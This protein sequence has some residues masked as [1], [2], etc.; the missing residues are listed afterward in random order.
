MGLTECD[1]D[2]GHTSP[3]YINHLPHDFAEKQEH[4]PY[5]PPPRPNLYLYSPSSNSLIPCEEI[6]VPNP[7]MSADGPVYSGPTNIYLAYPVQ[8]PDGIGYITQPFTPP[9]SYISQGSAS[10]SPSMSYD[11]TN[12]YSSTPHTFNSGRDSGWSTQPTSPPPPGNLQKPQ[13]TK[14][15][16]Y[17]H[18][19][20]TEGYYDPVPNNSAT[21]KSS[22]LNTPMS[23]TINTVTTQEPRQTVPYIPGLS[24]ESANTHKK[25][26]K[27]RKKKAKQECSATDFDILKSSSP[28]EI[29]NLK[30]NV[31]QHERTGE[32]V[33]EAPDEPIHE[34]HLTDDLADSLVNPPTDQEGS[35]EEEKNLRFLSHSQRPPQNEE[36]QEILNESEN[37]S[38]TKPRLANE[39]TEGEIEDKEICKITENIKEIKSAEYI[40]HTTEIDLGE[41]TKEDKPEYI[42]NIIETIDIGKVS[43]N[44]GEK[45]NIDADRKVKTE[46]V[47]SELECETEK[48]E[49]SKTFK[50]TVQSTKPLNKQIKISKKARKLTLKSEEGFL[51]SE[52]QVLPQ[53]ADPSAESKM[54]YSSVIKSSLITEL[55]ATHPTTNQPKAEPLSIY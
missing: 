6:I 52:H 4:V 3:F 2:S 33:V 54:S 40:K 38:E 20:Q 55:K 39:I 14:D 32:W 19:S 41:K 26:P 27:R 29:Y 51:E 45:H 7:V 13:G 50:T 24:L 53:N 28:D 18:L 36:S 37:S 46:C 12:C 15:M 11:G 22:N 21:D 16:P 8:G 49:K 43:V 1:I 48:S 10:Y 17:F 34:I 23:V 9:G 35:D 25:S 47:L 42:Q 5:G 31:I 30:A 44:S